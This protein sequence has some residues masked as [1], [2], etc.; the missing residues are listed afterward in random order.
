MA[1]AYAGNYN[2]LHD[3]LDINP[4]ENSKRFEL[5]LAA[6]QKY[7]SPWWHELRCNVRELAAMQLKEPVLLIRA[8]KL[9]EGV[10]LVLDRKVNEDELSA[11]NEALIAE[12]EA[13]YF[14]WKASEES[15]N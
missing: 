11:N 10:E 14:E 15:N 1:S 9:Q 8:S 6:M 3:E 7:S 2:Y 5:C 12:F 4:I 13:K